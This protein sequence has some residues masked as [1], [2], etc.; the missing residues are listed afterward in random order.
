MFWTQTY[1]EWERIEREG[2]A[3]ELLLKYSAKYV[4]VTLLMDSDEG[5][6][7]QRSS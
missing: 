7:D 1:R 5:N 6:F 4:S 2:K 3:T